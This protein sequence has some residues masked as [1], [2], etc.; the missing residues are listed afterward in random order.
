[1]STKTKS[2]VLVI[3]IAVAM[4]FLFGGMAAPFVRLHVSKL[5]GNW[6]GILWSGTPILLMLALFVLLVRVIF[7][8]K[9]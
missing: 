1:M 9:D 6:S 4:F 7:M 5:S 8:Q 3:S 2:G